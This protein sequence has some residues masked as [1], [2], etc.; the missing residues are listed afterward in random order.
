MYSEK[1]YMCMVKE[2]ICTFACVTIVFQSIIIGCILGVGCI[3]MD[4]RG[5]ISTSIIT[6]KSTSGHR[7][8]DGALR[9]L[10]VYTNHNPPPE[11]YYSKKQNPKMD[12]SDLREA[13]KNISRGKFSK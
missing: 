1:N 8:L 11:H 13:R 10:H 3:L 4:Y 5:N 12:P 7:G 9:T 6:K 2:Y